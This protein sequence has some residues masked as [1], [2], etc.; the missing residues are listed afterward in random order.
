[1]Q[2]PTQFCLFQNLFGTNRTPYATVWCDIISANMRKQCCLVS[3][4]KIARRNRKSPC[5]LVIS[6][7][8]NRWCGARPIIPLLY[9]G[10]WFSTRTLVSCNSCSH[11]RYQFLLA[12]PLP[13]TITCKC[14][15]QNSYKYGVSLCNQLWLAWH[16]PGPEG[17]CS[18]GWFNT[19]GA[20]LKRVIWD[21][22]YLQNYIS[23]KKAK[24]RTNQKCL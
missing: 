3:K 20:K 18:C 7:A 21:Y 2:E 17:S 13:N 16:T 10:L 11:L 4:K 8:V 24:S 15:T 6:A 12:L 19:F 23:F 9:I 14:D 1:M 22:F 5:V